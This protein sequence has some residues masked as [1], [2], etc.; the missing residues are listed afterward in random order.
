MKKNVF[1]ITFICLVINIFAQKVDKQEIEFEYKRMPKKPLNKDIKNYSSQVILKY[2]ADIIAEQEKA[3]DEYEKAVAEYPQ[4]VKN[5]KAKHNQAIMQ[6]EKEMAEWKNKPMGSKIL[7]KAILEEDNRPVHPGEFYTPKEPVLIEP[8]HQKVFDKDVL[9]NTYL[10]LEGYNKKNE[11]ALQITATLYGFENLEP[12][13]KFAPGNSYTDKKTGQRV[14]VVNYWYETI[15]KHPINLKIKTPTGETIL[16]ETL[17]ELNKFSLAKT[18]ASQ[19][20]RPEINKDVYMESLQNRIVETNMK[21]I[22]DYIND[23]YGFPKIKRSTIIYRVETKKLNYD[24]YQEA[25]ELAISGYN[26]LIDDNATA[27]ENINKAIQIW[28][29]ALTESNPADK[30]SRVNADISIITMFN[31]AEAL[32]WTDDYTK[33]D[34]YLNKIIGL[35]PSR[36]E[37]KSI[38]KYRD[39]IKEQKERWIANKID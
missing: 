30:K 17:E 28:E 39:F 38:E 34:M 32:I 12:E 21:Y 19:G 13:L 2:E 25:F 6:Y 3:K 14:D 33:A 27:R 7:E 37:M 35:K 9:A 4:K 15:Y 8:K 26:M 23:N 31:L 20:K 1:L 24:D 5:A 11:N 36:K 18:D 22:N 16:D 29:K 10:K